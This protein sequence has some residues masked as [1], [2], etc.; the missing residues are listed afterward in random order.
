M[1]LPEAVLSV[2][3]KHRPNYKKITFFPVQMSCTCGALLDMGT[4]HPGD[5]HRAHVAQ[6]LI[7][8]VSPWTQLYKPVRS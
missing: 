8:A 3:S 7:E 2:L 6:E 4:N 1:T 5:I